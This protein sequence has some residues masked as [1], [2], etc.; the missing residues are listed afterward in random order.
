M[1]SANGISVGH[2]ALVAGRAQRAA[3]VADL[4][5]AASLEALGGNISALAALQSMKATLQGLPASQRS[6]TYQ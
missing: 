2:A 4:S 6:S 5:A 1:M 3:K